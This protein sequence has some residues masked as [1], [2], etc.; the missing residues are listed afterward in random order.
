MQCPINCHHHRRPHRQK[1]NRANCSDAAKVFRVQ[2]QI[3]TIVVQHRLLA[4]PK[5]GKVSM[6]V[7]NRKRSSVNM[8]NVLDCLADTH[9]VQIVLA[10]DMLIVRVPNCQSVRRRKVMANA[11]RRRPVIDVTADAISDVCSTKKTINFPFISN[12]KKR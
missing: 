12:L 2:C 9:F 8:P 3:P 7:R 1:P 6:N 10:N 5:P 11:H 4:P